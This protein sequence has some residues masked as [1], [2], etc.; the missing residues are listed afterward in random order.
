MLTQK[1][2]T[3][4]QLII[5]GTLLAA[6][7]EIDSNTNT[8]SGSGNGS[9]SDD[10]SGTVTASV[11][12]GVTNITSGL[13]L[14]WNT[15]GSGYSSFNLCLATEAINDQF[16]QCNALDGGDYRVGVSAPLTLDNLAPSARYW[17]Q[18]EG[19]RSGTTPVYSKVLVGVPL[20]PDNADVGTA[21][22]VVNNGYFG[23]YNPRNLNRAGAYALIT[24]TSQSAGFRSS[25]GTEATTE[26][27]PVDAPDEGTEY[28]QLELDLQ[29]GY[30][31]TLAVDD[32]LYF[33]AIHTGS[34][35]TQRDIWITDGTSSGTR[36][37]VDGSVHSLRT[38]RYFVEVDG[39]V[40]FV[41][42]TA[43]DVNTDLFYV[44]DEA[45][46]GGARQ[47]ADI[48]PNTG[49]VG[50][51][52]MGFKGAF[53][54]SVSDS[55]HRLLKVDADTLEVETFWTMPSFTAEQRAPWD[56]TTTDNYLYF[57]ARD[58]FTARNNSGEALWRTDGVSDPVRLFNADPETRVDGDI[59][60]VSNPFR[61]GERIFFYT[62]VWDTSRIPS[63]WHPNRQLAVAS[64]N[65]AV[66]RVWGSALNGSLS[67]SGNIAGN[68][69][70]HALG[71]RLLFKSSNLAPN[72]RQWW[73]TDGTSA[74]TVALLIDDLAI[75]AP[76]SGAPHHFSADSGRG[77]WITDDDRE[78]LYF[79][80]RDLAQSQAVDGTFSIV[81]NLI[82]I[83]GQLWF[84]GAQVRFG[85][86]G[87]WRVP[88][89]A[90]D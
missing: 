67:V 60:R 81:D 74:N 69:D 43:G 42:Y 57:T 14:T 89:V 16:D 9:G 28:K 66:S 25:L 82:E 45:A 51:K 78:K 84:T 2:L 77:V 47:L 34:G 6:C 8:G 15:T 53:Y 19:E 30:L 49:G 29:S 61:V 85:P 59:Y 36:R 76:P 5:F 73:I 3:V 75:D 37:I 17:I 55:S 21:L 23:T 22:E 86:V 31:K 62:T 39:T 18:I 46:P 44:I 38:L 32:Q 88:Q 50:R 48:Q 1:V 68:M 11:Q 80:G 20:V 54:V 4:A 35:L 65:G 13:E 79:I 63:D 41:A 71:E 64:D 87:V 52:V 70:I 58:N 40:G 90:A 83:G 7:F 10:G 12:L 33:I 24:D 26:Y 72:G 27:I 56:L